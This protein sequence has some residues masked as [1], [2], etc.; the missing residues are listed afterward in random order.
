[1][2]VCVHVDVSGEQKSQQ[3]ALARQSREG[4]RRT[5]AR[6]CAAFSRL[7]SSGCSRSKNQV[8]RPVGKGTEGRRRGGGGE[9]AVPFLSS[10]ACSPCAAWWLAARDKHRGG[11]VVCVCVLRACVRCECV[12]VCVCVSSFGARVC[13]CVSSFG[14]RVCVCVCVCVASVCVCV[15]P[16]PVRLLSS[17][18]PPATSSWSDSKRKCHNADK[19]P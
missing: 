9:G 10:V 14:A 19:Q 11:G 2:C 3:Q 7:F 6:A 15:V 5:C 12:C 1:M 17:S 18:L 16:R 4:R 8:S 13:V